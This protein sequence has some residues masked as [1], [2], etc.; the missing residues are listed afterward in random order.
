M[1]LC[2]E[3]GAPDCS[4]EAYKRDPAGVQARLERWALIAARR[5][6]HE[7]DSDDSGA[8]TEAGGAEAQP[9]RV[10]SS[11]V[12]PA[13]LRA[14]HAASAGV[15]RGV[16]RRVA[17]A[18]HWD[19]PS[20]ELRVD[21]FSRLYYSSQGDFD[22]TITEQGGRSPLQDVGFQGAQ[23]EALQQFTP[24]NDRVLLFA[25]PALISEVTRA[26]VAQRDAGGTAVIVAP[27]W[28]NQTW[29]QQLRELGG[30]AVME[31]EP[32]QAGV[33]VWVDGMPQKI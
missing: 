31:W 5:R 7:A 23:S 24:S 6:T 20:L 19:D 25:R 18:E 21:E 8:E 17:E 1:Q 15:L 11:L 2:V 27:A 3:R 28:R 22:R 16:R 4:W 26:A 29:H 10:E 13:V 30:E 12:K 33:S 9:E 14:P 32:R